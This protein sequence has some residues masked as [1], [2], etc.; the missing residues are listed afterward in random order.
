MSKFTPFSQR[1]AQ[2]FDTLSQGE[3]FVTQPDGD[4]LWD[5]YLQSFP[6]GTNPIF[7]ERT[8]HDCSCCRQFIRNVGSVVSITNGKLVTVWDDL[9]AEYPYDVV[10]STMASYVRSL[11]I[12]GLFRANERKFG[13]EH[14]FE[15]TPGEVPIKWTHFHADIKDKHYSRTVGADTGAYATSVQ[16]FRR[17]LIELAPAAFTMVVELIEN[18]S[19]YRGAE[20]L[21]AIKA[22]QKLQKSYNALSFE[23]RDAFTWERANHPAARFR[24]TAIGTLIQDLSEGIDL[25]RAVASFE[26]KVAP[27]NYKR[28][29]SLI[30]PRMIDDAMATIRSLDLEPALN[31]RFAKLSDVSVNNVLWVDNA[32]Q[33]YMR[34]GIEGLLMDA[35]ARPKPGK[36]KAEAISIEDFMANVLPKVSA[37]NAFVTNTQQPNFMSL[38]APVE[39]DAGDLFKW[40]NN[41]AWS[42]DGNITDSIK[43]KVKA[44]GGNTTAALRISLAWFNRDDLDIHVIEPNGNRINFRNKSGKLDV[45]MNAGY[46]ITRE[47]VENVSFQSPADGTYQVIVNQFNKRETQD[48]GFVIEVEN[49]GSVSQFSYTKPVTGNVE[50]ALITVVNGRITRTIL[51]PALVGGGITQE[52]WGI[53]TESFVKVSTVMHSPNHWDGNAVGNKHWFF[54]LDECLNDEPARGIYNEFLKSDL[55]KHRKVF[56]ILGNKTKCPPT[57]DQLSGLGFSST[58]ADSVLVQ[59]TGDKL[60]KAYTINF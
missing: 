16:V 35:V 19:L 49:E 58:R 39:E 2:R 45:D 55:E 21:T 29:T 17:G 44:A 47:P 12:Q 1:I 53:T 23:D 51:N 8:E 59:V 10:A 5:K 50:A 33:P 30:T 36:M 7:R 15:V 52:K 20:F 42:Y 37:M 48:V 31:R 34:D 14:N 60:N 4:T 46:G 41:F 13:T 22:F 38:T 40:Q 3:L 24:N 25:E 32:V 28:P 57:S 11:P 43:E 9:D 56:E 54:I 6:E 18:N 27:T 26:A